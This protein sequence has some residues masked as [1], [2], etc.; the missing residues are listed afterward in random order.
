MYCTSNPQAWLKFYEIVNA[1]PIVP[2]DLECIALENYIGGTVEGDGR[3]DQEAGEMNATSPFNSVHLCEAPG[4]FILA[5]N[6]Y[7]ALN[8][9]SLKVGHG[10]NS[11]V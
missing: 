10:Y 2:P 5:L 7:L 11:W 8:R 4:A 6:H 1:Y 9:S 3:E